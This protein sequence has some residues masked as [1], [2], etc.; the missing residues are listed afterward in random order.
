MLTVTYITAQKWETIKQDYFGM[1]YKLPD[2][3]EI[4]GFGG[5]DWE[6]TGSSVCDCAGTINIGNRFSEKEIYM[7]VYPSRQKD[8]ID[9]KKRR[10]VWDME[11]KDTINSVQIKT[12]Y[13]FFTKKVSKWKEGTEENYAGSEVWQLK[14]SFKNQYYLI[15]FFAKPEVINENEPILIEIINN[16]QPV[17]AK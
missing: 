1:K 7:V 15:Y 5:N 11:F 16:F 3:W 6:E 2:S 14:T 10:M 4:D 17:K 13:C 12:K 8:S 9:N